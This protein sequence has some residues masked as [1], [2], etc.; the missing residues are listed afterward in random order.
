M[1]GQTGY[2]EWMPAGF[3][4]HGQAKIAY[5]WTIDYGSALSDIWTGR[6]CPNLNTTVC[7]CQ[8]R[9]AKVIGV[10][11]RIW[12]GG[13]FLVCH[14]WFAQFSA[15]LWLC[16]SSIVQELAMLAMEF[17]V[18]QAFMAR[19]FLQRAEQQFLASITS[20]ITST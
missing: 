15:L 2:V 18:Y 1:M 10:F 7:I 13:F 17:S 6:W 5:E 12:L 14:S 20:A 19:D 9:V 11:L 4:C 3:M 16:K 8:E